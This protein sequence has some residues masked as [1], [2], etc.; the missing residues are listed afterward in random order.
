MGMPQ[1]EVYKLIIVMLI[2]SIL[3]FN[4]NKDIAETWKMALICRK[5]QTPLVLCDYEI[6]VSTVKIPQKVSPILA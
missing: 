1:K 4:I 3:T 5:T 2:H 6:Y